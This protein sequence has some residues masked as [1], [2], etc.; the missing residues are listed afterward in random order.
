MKS[1]LLLIA[2]CASAFGQAQRQ[3]WSPNHLNPVVWLEADKVIGLVADGA[4]IS[5]SILDAAGYNQR[6]LIGT[7]GPVYRKSVARLNNRPGFEMGTTGGFTVTQFLNNPYTMAV[8][9]TGDSAGNL[10]RAVAGL[11][12]NS[13]ITVGF[14][15]D[16]LSAYIGGAVATGAFTNNVGIG[17]LTTGTQSR[18]YL[19]GVDSTTTSTLLTDW[20]WIV[21]GMPNQFSEPARTTVAAVIAFRRVLTTAERV[22]L[23]RYFGTKYNFS[24]P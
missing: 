19:N 24:V 8:V 7:A 22:Q 10:G 23:Q 4:T 5:A 3:G 9:E 6:W 13:L 2:L 1:F 11:D 20:G 18:Y 14:R 15:P 16:N 21:T 17:I 12:T